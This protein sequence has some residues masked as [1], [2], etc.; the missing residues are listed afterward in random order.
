MRRIAIVCCSALAVLATLGAGDSAS[1]ADASTT[2]PATTVAPT[3]GTTA[4]TAA[5]PPVDV[6]EVSGLV[7]RVLADWISRSVARSATNGAQA[8][9]IQLNSKGDTVGEAR[10][11]QL[12]EQIHA[13][14]IP[15]T[16]WVGPSGSTAYGRAG[17]LLGAAA[18]TGMAPGSRIG[19]FGGP[20]PV[21]GFELTFG[22]A[23]TTLQRGTL[24]AAEARTQ[25]ALKPGPDGLGT[26]TLG[27]F[28]VSLDGL[29]Y[30]GTT[31][32]TARVV[33]AGGQPRRVPTAT[34]RFY[35]VELVPRLF[36]TVASPP[37]AYLLLTIGLVLLIF[38]FFTAGV[39]VA[40]IIG[41]GSLVLAL[42]GLAELP[43]RGWAVALIF[44][45]MFAFAID[46]QTGV[47]RF[48][49]WF[50]AASFALASVF[51]YDGILVSWITLLA[52]IGGVLLA[53][54][55]GMPSMVRTRFA[56]PTIGREWMIGEVG[57]AV[58]P[59]NPDGVVRIRDAQWRARTNRATPI[60]EG[61][62][63]RVVAIIG[64]TLEVEPEEGGARDH[65]ER[66]RR[67]AGEPTS[68]GSDGHP[69]GE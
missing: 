32:E 10:M 8:L 34:P 18:V 6:V 19:D 5:N 59:V 21:T 15:V 44:L 43:A 62:R 67:P 28:L 50:G 66:A 3:A 57:E 69:D 16:I 35:K 24:G 36:H 9:I 7:D 33:D 46:V 47:P 13:S 64:T 55:A 12:A 27:D 14:P 65:R 25:G 22:A 68:E 41:A 51:L 17:Q 38:E 31:V 29:Q 39:G 49:T 63:A 52:G 1:A 4:A 42:Y 45:A 30:M 20:L 60:A 54:L 23:T 48:W 58:V 11:A 37:V 40:G 2:T 61:A 56:T 26:P 53:F